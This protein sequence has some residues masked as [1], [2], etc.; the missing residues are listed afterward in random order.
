MVRRVPSIRAVFTRFIIHYII[1][2]IVISCIGGYVYNR[3]YELSKSEAI[4]S[5]IVRLERSMALIETRLNEVESIATQ[6][7]LDARVGSLMSA[8]WPY[9]GEQYYGMKALSDNLANYKIGNRLVREAFVYL[10]KGAFI[11]SFHPTADVASFYGKLLQFGDLTYEQWR[12]SMLEDYRYAA[13][14]PE[15]SVMANGTRSRVI[16]YVQSIP[17]GALN[18]YKGAVVVLLD[19]R[20][21]QAMLAG[22]VPPGEGWAYI[23]KSD[24]SI[25]TGFGNPSPEQLREAVPA[26]GRGY[27][28]KTIDGVRMI[29]MRTTPGANGWQYVAAIPQSVIA[30]SVAY[31][32][33]MYVY[34][35]IVTV[36]AGL[37]IAVAFSYTSSRPIMNLLRKLRSGFGESAANAPLR[38]AWDYLDGTITEL[39]AERA[40]LKRDLNRQVDIVKA[41]F[42]ERLLRGG[43]TKEPDI[44][45]MRAYLD[46]DL[47]GDRFVAAVIGISGAE[48]TTLTPD[49]LQRLDL[50]KLIVQEKFSG[51]LPASLKIYPLDERRSVL[52]IGMNEGDVQAFRHEL[53]TAAEHALEALAESLGEGVGL[54]VGVGKPCE[55]LI[56]IRNSFDEALQALEASEQSGKPS[57]GQSTLAFYGDIRQEQDIYYYPTDVETRLMNLVKAGDENEVRRIV[58]E[59]RERN[60]GETKLDPEMIAQLAFEMRGT[61]VK[62]RKAV[63]AADPSQA[64]EL[65]PMMDD[66]IGHR[67]AD[68]LFERAET[69]FAALSAIAQ[70]RLP[71]Q[72]DHWR[73]KILT[74]MHDRF[75]RDDLSLT[76]LATELGIKEKYVSQL[77]KEQIGESFTQYLERLRMDRAAQLLDDPAVPVQDISR[78]S[79]YATPNTFYKAFKR[80]YGIS[81]SVYRQQQIKR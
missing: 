15:S 65:E 26:S 3:S 43:F 34:T 7:A 68:P 79:G 22:A 78:L 4:E 2:L 47:E 63:G 21:V 56:R 44:E 35:M 48:A 55:H 23:A 77:F 36:I 14:F 10:N 80:H 8:Q 69:L 70:E 71:G 17:I 42:L 58:D 32:K 1:L 72:K 60:S 41:T 51:L 39:I 31:I 67:S 76:T 29:V 12:Q 37:L 11:S 45:A 38:S 18:T 46:L 13:Y 61:A 19:A 64:E 28:E 24:G 75:D 73:E 59:L 81:P 5:G 49:L 66:L 16:T 9:E 33:R 52:L 27:E 54:A 53:E 57:S 74:I 30:D 20:E 6:I 50:A 62:L 40:N 25:V